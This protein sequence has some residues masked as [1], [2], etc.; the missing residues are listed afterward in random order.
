MII[1]KEINN[2]EPF[3][4]VTGTL[5]MINEIGVFVVGDLPHNMR[6]V[7]EQE[8]NDDMDVEECIDFSLPIGKSIH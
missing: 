8:K 4:Q 3:F 1:D 2:L 6:E 7:C 5:G